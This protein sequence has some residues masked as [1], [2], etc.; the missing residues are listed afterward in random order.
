MLIAGTH[1]R[2]IHPSQQDPAISP[3]SCNYHTW[4]CT[5]DG[6]AWL[7]EI[8]ALTLLNPSSG[9]EIMKLAASDG[10]KVVLSGS[11]T[12]ATPARTN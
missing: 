9:M 4:I 1:R 7:V 8:L 10:S 6:A 2:S 12:F 11:V 5:A 3:G